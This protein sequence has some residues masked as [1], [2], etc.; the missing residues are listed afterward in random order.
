MWPCASMRCHVL[1]V[2]KSSWQRLV[3]MN[4]TCLTT[5]YLC[6]AMLRFLPLAIHLR[7]RLAAVPPKALVP[8]ARFLPG[9]A[10]VG[11]AARSI[12]P[13]R[14]ATN[15]TCAQLPL[16]AKLAHVQILLPLCNRRAK[17][18]RKYVPGSSP[19]ITT[20]W[21]WNKSSRFVVLIFFLS[22]SRTLACCSAAFKSL[23]PSNNIFTM[24]S[25]SALHTVALA[26]ATWSVAC[27]R[28]TQN[29]VCAA[30]TSTW[31]TFPFFFAEKDSTAEFW[32]RRWS[33]SPAR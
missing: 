9:L 10:R 13:C 15:H 32:P 22:V 8:S 20:Q 1:L 30:F 2:S 14:A 27:A 23:P 29:D 21:Q 31:C 26:A 3:W 7:C 5:Y 4:G 28:I 16:C 6:A 17:H 18:L 33:A 24:A 12:C 25:A 11:T 19:W